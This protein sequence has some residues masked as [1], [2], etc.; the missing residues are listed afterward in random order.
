[1]RRT[2]RQLWPL[3]QTL[4]PSLP[5]SFNKG[6]CGSVANTERNGLFQWE[7]RGNMTGDAEKV[8][9]GQLVLVLC[10]MW[11]KMHLWIKLQDF[12]KFRLCLAHPEVSKNSLSNSQKFVASKICI[13]VAKKIILLLRIIAIVLHRNC[14]KGKERDKYVWKVLLFLFSMGWLSKHLSTSVFHSY[15]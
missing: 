8:C 14:R 1:M 9:P 2:Q 4:L 5:L 6:H 12:C 7:K 15:F 3:C 10:I 11:L 13:S